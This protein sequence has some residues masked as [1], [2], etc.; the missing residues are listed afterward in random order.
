MVKGGIV[1]LVPPASVECVEVIF[2]VELKS[3]GVKVVGVSLNIVK[4]AIPWHINWMEPVS[5]SLKGWGPE[6]HHERLALVHV[7]NSGVFTVDPPN[8]VAINAPRNEVRM[9]N[10]FVDVPIVKG[11]EVMHIVM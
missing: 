3:V 5:P 11:V 6:V 2:P 4:D 8:F 10:H 1:T 7:P 9:P